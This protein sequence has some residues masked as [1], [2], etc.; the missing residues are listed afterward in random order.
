[1]TLVVHPGSGSRNWNLD[2]HFN[3][4]IKIRMRDPALR[5]RVLRL[6]SRHSTSSPFQSS[7]RLPASH[8]TV[9]VMDILLAL[10][11]SRTPASSL[12]HTELCQPQEGHQLLHL[13]CDVCQHDTHG[14]AYDVL[15]YSHC[16]TEGRWLTGGNLQVRTSTLSHQQCCVITCKI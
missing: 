6:R 4:K 14:A 11:C 1:M 13:A 3:S 8:I 5:T 7:F 16:R 9:H 12:K 15:Y 10:S 2:L